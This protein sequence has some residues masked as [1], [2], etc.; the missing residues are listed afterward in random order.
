ME[1]LLFLILVM[2][3]LVIFMLFS[4]SSVLVKIYESLHYDYQLPPKEKEKK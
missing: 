4:M 2:L 1:F 3:L